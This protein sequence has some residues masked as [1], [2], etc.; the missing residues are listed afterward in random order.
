MVSQLTRLNSMFKLYCVML[1]LT[2]S[3]CSFPG[4]KFLKSA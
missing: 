1:I 3:K 2:T 4:Q